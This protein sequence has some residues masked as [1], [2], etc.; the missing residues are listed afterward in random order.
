MTEIKNTNETTND[1]TEKTPKVNLTAL[2]S[3]QVKKTIEL[4]DQQG[5]KTGKKVDITMEEVD[6]ETRL[7]IDDLQNVGNNLTDQGELSRQLLENVLVNPRLDF[8]YMNEQIEAAGYGKKSLTF[9]GKDGKKHKYDVIFPGYGD[10]LNI[11]S[12]TQG[13]DGAFNF[14]G[15]FTDVNRFVV[16]DTKGNPVNFNFWDKAENLYDVHGDITKFLREATSVNGYLQ[17]IGELRSF[18]G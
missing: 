3:K 18:L 10:A 8:E 11:L 15:F 6:W 16:R 17:I 7:R 4:I 14:L 5:K 9:V 13:V 2:A 12:E 1:S